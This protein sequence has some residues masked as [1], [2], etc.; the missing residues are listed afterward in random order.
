[1][2]SDEVVTLRAFLDEQAALETAAKEV[3]PGK[4]D[5]CTYDLGYI[6]QPVYVCQSCVKEG[7]KAGSAAIC[8]SCSIQCHTH[9][10]LIELM[11]RRDFRC[12]CG[13]D[14]FTS[15]GFITLNVW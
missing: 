6:N 11:Y 5:F 3:L 14:K 1:M 2:I 4:F 10:E 12:D 8:Y 9:C 15:T 13:N 7:A